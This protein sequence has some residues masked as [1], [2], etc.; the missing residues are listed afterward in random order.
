MARWGCWFF[1]FFL[2]FFFRKQT[3]TWPCTFVLV[4]ACVSVCLRVSVYACVRVSAC[5]FSGGVLLSSQSLMYDLFV[6]I[7][8]SI[9][10]VLSVY[11]FSL[12]VGFGSLDFALL[13][14]VSSVH[15]DQQ[16]EWRERECVCVWDENIQKGTS[17]I[18]K[19]HS[20]RTRSLAF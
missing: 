3:W 17:Q 14:L 19:F 2:F 6:K 20:Q 8:T 5:Y 9:A 10:A 16:C 13:D 7:R 12:S 11:F 18:G 15:T 1:F 4:S